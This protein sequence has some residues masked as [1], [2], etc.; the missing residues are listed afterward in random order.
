MRFNIKSSLILVASIILI[1]CNHAFAEV[2]KD[3]VMIK[4]GTFFMGSDMGNIVMPHGGMNNES[5]VHD[6]KLDGF[7][8][9]KYP[10]TNEQYTKF[11]KATKYMTYSE[12]TPKAEDWPGAKPEMLVPASIVFKSDSEFQLTIN[13]LVLM[14][15]G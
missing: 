13:N 15:L 9:D 5:P 12:Q 1:V 11:V 3:M 6:V 4:G 8:I 2:P 7:W 10:V 14:F